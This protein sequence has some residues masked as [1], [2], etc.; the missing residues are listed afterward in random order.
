[1]NTTVAIVGAGGK[2]GRRASERLGAT[3]GYIA[4]NCEK[5]PR[6]AELL[7]QDGF[8]VTE[9][10]PAVSQ[11]DFVILAVPDEAI[12]A[13][14]RSILPS[15]KPDCTLIALDA[16][17][18]YIGE[19]PT[20]AGITQMI[21]H[22]CHPALFGRQKTDAAR[23]D[24]FGGTAIQDILVALVDGSEEAF[25]RGSEVCRILFAPVHRTHRVTLEQFAFLE[26]AMSEIIVAT[27]A[28]LIR[29]SLDAAIDRGVPR[30]AAQAFMAGHAQIALA[31]VF[32]VE[33]SPFSDACKI[34]I[35]WG[36]RELIDPD[37]RRVFDR[38]ILSE[39]IREMIKPQ[40]A[41]EELHV[42]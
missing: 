27:A 11:A 8:P 14:T 21:T 40:S 23:D 34:A 5:D 26:P 19:I 24:H 4:L 25:A 10:I 16:A 32:G 30:E 33:P 31:I 17:A 7:Q 22:P 18:A 29:A 39:A 42:Q 13:I 36:T 12:G 38:A 41:R 3:P 15:V 28:T 20:R 37:W 2:M 9:L 6:S 35:E 1:M